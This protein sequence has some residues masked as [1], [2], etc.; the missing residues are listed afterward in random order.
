MQGLIKSGN[1]LDMN[2]IQAEIDK[3]NYIDSVI[4]AYIALGVAKKESALLEANIGAKESTL[5]VMEIKLKNG[6]EIALNAKKLSNEIVLLKQ[7]LKYNYAQ[8]EKSAEQFR[9]LTALTGIAPMWDAGSVPVVPDAG[10]NSQYALDI[11]KK[12]LEIANNSIDLGLA[13]REHFLPELSLSFNYGYD[14]WEQQ[15][16]WGFSAGLSFSL[17]DFFER[18]NKIGQLNYQK[19]NNEIALQNLIKEFEYSLKLMRKR[20]EV[21]T[22]KV[23]ALKG[24]VEIEREL[25]KL[26]DYQYKTDAIEYPEYMLLMNNLLQAEL[27]YLRAESELYLLKKRLQYGLVKI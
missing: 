24:N 2:K 5:K 20:I 10:S 27:T 7:D 15:S 19:N 26:Y 16:S 8:Q 14:M 21:L 23:S 4:Q 13:A 25:Q 18:E 3:R 22:E 9:I 11:G 12:T 17:F 1:Q 6:Q